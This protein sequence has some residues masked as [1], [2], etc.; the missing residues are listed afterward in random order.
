MLPDID[1]FYTSLAEHIKIERIKKKV[2]QQDLADHLSLS[3][4]S[5]INIETGRHRPSIYQI[6]QIA[7]YLKIDFTDLVPFKMKNQ[8]ATKKKVTVDVKKAVIDEGSLDKS[9]QTAVNNFLSDLKK[10]ES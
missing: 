7:A 1:T 10:D 5:M 6:L 2:N 8:T 9:Q 4:T 3:R